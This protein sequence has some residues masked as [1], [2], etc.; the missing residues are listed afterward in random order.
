MKRGRIVGEL[1]GA[2]RC[3][4]LDGR[5]LVLVADGDSGRLLVAIDTLDARAGQEALVALGSGGRN[6]LRPG[7]DNR[8]LLC[9][10][11]VALLI[12]GADDV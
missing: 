4:G 9:D 7:P 12:D 1:W 10:A 8:D 3:R 5:R 6:V 11:A 2:R